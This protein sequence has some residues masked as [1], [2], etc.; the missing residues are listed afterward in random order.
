M[1]ME[2]SLIIAVWAYPQLYDPSLPSYRDSGRRNAA[3][4]KVAKIVGFTGGYNS[5]L[6][7]VRWMMNC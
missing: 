7:N 6:D 5:Y 2:D 3:W 4:R 1:A